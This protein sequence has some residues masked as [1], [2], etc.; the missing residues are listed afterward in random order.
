MTITDHLL[1]LLAEEAGEVTQAATKALR[2][3]LND[4]NPKTE[5]INKDN[6]IFEFNDLLAVMELLNDN[7]S[8][9]TVIDRGLIEQKKLKISKY[10]EQSKEK[11]QVQNG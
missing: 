5:I 10:M 7:N 9:E 8:I 11:G 6:I 3:G 2:F 1:V 4:F